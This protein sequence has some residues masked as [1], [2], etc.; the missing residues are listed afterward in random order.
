MAR[1]EAGQTP[2]ISQEKKDQTTRHI[3]DKVLVLK[4]WLNEGGVPEGYN[5]PGWTTKKNKKVLSGTE[6]FRVWHDPELEV[7]VRG[8]TIKGIFKIGSPASLNKEWNVKHVKQAVELI[9]ALNRLSTTKT[10]DVVKELKALL[11]AEETLTQDLQ[12]QVVMVEAE[13]ESLDRE[14][15]RLRRRYKEMEEDLQRAS[16]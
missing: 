1:R 12:N 16:V 9:K 14:N 13:N 5:W 2:Q 11:K 6:A 4:T 10:S 3:K 15:D 7:K 8:K